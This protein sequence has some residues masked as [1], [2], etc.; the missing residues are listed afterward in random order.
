[1]IAKLQTLWQEA[2][3]D[4]NATVEAFFATGFSPD[5]HHC[6][7]ENGIPV[8]AL[9]WFDCQ[10]DGQKLAYIYAVATLTSHRGK[11]L[12]HRLMEQTHEILKSRGYAGA[13]L[14][15]ATDLFPF[16]EQL[17]YRATASIDKFTCRAD[18]VAIPLREIPAEEY[19]RLRKVF[20]P[21]GAVI[22]EGAA[23]AGLKAEVNTR[24]ILPQDEPA[25]LPKLKEGQSINN[26][27][28]TSVSATDIVGFHNYYLDYRSEEA[29]V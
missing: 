3:G 29:H 17:G 2:F 6:I 21:A 25:V 20:L 18:G 26:R 10:L 9:Y 11:G 27:T 5:R 22:Q 1:M 19:A 28:L 24:N 15:P 13:V 14:V 7:V 4:S 8:S 12:A 23:L 16:Y